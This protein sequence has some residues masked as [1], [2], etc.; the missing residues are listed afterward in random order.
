MVTL[1]SLQSAHTSLV[2][3]LWR[4][5]NSIEALTPKIMLPIYPVTQIAVFW[6]VMSQNLMINR[7]QL[8][9]HISMCA[10]ARVSIQSRQ[11]NKSS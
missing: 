1:L 9:C 6:I 5:C 7:A 8:T 10:S 11:A 4:V 3:S 2:C